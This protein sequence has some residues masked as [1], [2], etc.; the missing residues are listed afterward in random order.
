M[1]D[2]MTVEVLKA[3]ENVVRVPPRSVQRQ[4]LTR[5]NPQMMQ[6]SVVMFEHDVDLL[7]V[8]AAPEDLG[9]HKDPVLEVFEA[10][11]DLDS[12]IRND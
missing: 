7:N 2:S 4:K 11:V 6:A 3:A 8:D 12:A 9:G 10:F 5:G 1:A